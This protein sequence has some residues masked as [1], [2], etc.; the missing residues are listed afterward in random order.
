MQ[1]EFSPFLIGVLL[2]VGSV[3]RLEETVV[4]CLLRLVDQSIGDLGMQQ[5]SEW[6]SANLSKHSVGYSLV[7]VWLTQHK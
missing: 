1:V 3:K 4:K 7:I 5:R 2:A 6:L